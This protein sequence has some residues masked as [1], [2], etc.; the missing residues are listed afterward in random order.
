M[1]LLAS[2]GAENSERTCQVE[3][4]CLMPARMGN[5]TRDDTDDTD[6]NHANFFQAMQ[7]SDTGLKLLV[8]P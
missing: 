5:E 2:F 8:R 7:S 4:K 3:E 6:A 1:D